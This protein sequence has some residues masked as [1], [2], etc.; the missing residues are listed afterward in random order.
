MK[1]LKQFGLFILSSAFVIHAN[2]AMQIDACS[3]LPTPVQSN[4]N[5]WND[6][7]LQGNNI[8]NNIDNLASNVNAILKVDA[9]L[10]K[11][12]S[13]LTA[14]TKTFGTLIPVV[15][16]VAS[17]KNVFTLANDTFG[18]LNNKGVKP[19]H[20]ITDQIATKSGIKALQSKLD[21]EVKPQIQ[22]IVDQASKNATELTAQLS[23]FKSAC[24]ALANFNQS[25]TVPTAQIN[26]LNTSSTRIVADL[27]SAQNDFVALEKK[28][29]SNLKDVQS[30]ID[31]SQDM[32]KAVATLKSPVDAIAGSVGKV[33]DLLSKKIKIK[34]A[35]FNKS[36][37]LK[38]AF[39]EVNSIIKTI[40]KIPG[41][42]NVERA[43]NKPITA[44]MDEVTKPMEQAI[45]P[46][47][48]GLKPPSF[49]LS[50]FS[51]KIG[52]FNTITNDL[53]NSAN[54]ATKRYQDLTGMLNIANNN[55]G[56]KC[57]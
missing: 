6:I 46:L 7:A 49:S 5:A 52:S 15:S 17:V 3:K 24:S 50:S 53:N 41:V 28:V 32:E 54:N 34:V 14:A 45:K 33:G 31:F 12:E 2:A 8:I 51:T 43:V 13:D 30:A 4:I 26:Q 9:D 36:F 23:K 40:K 20:N 35:T 39:K 56:I 57:N 1:M 25:C 37:T 21:K 42:K 47:Q 19:S 48:K 22:K 27:T 16:P 10:K 29:N 55:F 38:S 44:V 11:M 18:E